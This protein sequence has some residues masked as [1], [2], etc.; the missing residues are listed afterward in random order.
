MK[1]KYVYQDNVH[2]INQM[3][4]GDKLANEAHEIDE[5]F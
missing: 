3:L 5:Q 4:A 2:T 1:W